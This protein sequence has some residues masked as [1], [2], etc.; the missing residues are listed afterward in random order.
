MKKKD[1]RFIIIFLAIL[2][3]AGVYL[4]Q[5]SY[6]KYRRQIKSDFSATI[7]SWNIKVNNEMI[8]NKTELT[9]TITPVI[10]NSTYVKQ[11]T[12]APGTTGYFDLTIDATLVDV[13]FTYT[14]DV[15]PDV[16]TPLLDFII[17][18]YTIGATTV[19]LQP[20]DSIIE[21]LVKN[22]GTTSLRINFAW[23]DSATNQMDNEADTEYAID[24]NHTNTD[25][26]VSIN[27]IQ[28]R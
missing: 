14:I 3:F 28:K 26:T 12:I 4:F 6:A 1:I 24:T 20:G 18:S 19:Y 2:I 27:F 8:N 9:N 25:V 23:D 21:D 13:D 7:A 10:N 5:T 16:D 22:T 15:E 11:G 17:T